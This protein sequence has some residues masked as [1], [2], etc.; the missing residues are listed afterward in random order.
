M[1]DMKHQFKYIRV[2]FTNSYILDC[3]EGY[4]L[5]DTGYPDDFEKF[6]QKLKNKYQI[7][8]SE[9]KYLLLTHHHDDHAGFAKILIEKSG[10]T[11]IVHE[12]ALEQL[13]FGVSEEEG[14]PVNRRMK[15]IMN[16][17]SQFHE[18]KFPPIIPSDNDIILKGCEDNPDILRDLGIKGTIIFTPGHT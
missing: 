12:N 17:F 4:L 18:F 7:K 8:I 3:N 5:I 1:N 6:V 2:G 15:F 13:K 11:L 16:L 9:L 14:R 10:A